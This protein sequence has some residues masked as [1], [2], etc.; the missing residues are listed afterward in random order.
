MFE[1]HN[2]F[3][4]LVKLE[5]SPFAISSK[6]FESHIYS[7]LANSYPTD[8]LIYAN[9]QNFIRNGLHENARY[10]IPICKLAG[11]EGIAPIWLDAIQ[12]LGGAKFRDL[13]VRIF[14]SELLK[15]YG[16]SFLEFL[17]SAE[18]GLRGI[19]D[20]PLLFDFQ[21]GINSPCSKTSTVRGTHLDNPLEI[22]ALLL[23]FPLISCVDAGLVV[24]R[25]TGSI[26][27]FGKYEFSGDFEPI[28]EVPYA[29]NHGVLFLNTYESFHSVQP[30]NASVDSRKLVNVI[31]ELNPKHRPPLF[32]LR[33]VLD[34]GI[35]PSVFKRFLKSIYK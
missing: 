26:F 35:S 3:G 30:R 1:P 34:R 20:T 24:E 2:S 28:F 14:E 6:F 22:F 33:D 27:K 18:V 5:G 10:Q 25:C 4:S 12:S 32:T 8:C 13:S 23:Y 7:L 11:L 31:L 9:D 15:Y 19:D 29:P 16:E 17:L 21:I